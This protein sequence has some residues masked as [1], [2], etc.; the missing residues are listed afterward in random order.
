[1]ESLLKSQYNVLL[2]GQS[3]SGKTSTVAN[4]LASLDKRQI[5]QNI[6]INFSAR[7]TSLRVQQV[8]EDQLIQKG[9]TYLPQIGRQGIIYV[10]DLNM[11][12]KDQY[13][14]SQPIEF[15]RFFMDTKGFYDRKDLFWKNV[16]NTCILSSCAQP[17][18]GRETLTTRLTTSFVMFAQ[19]E[20]EDEGL[21]KIYNTILEGYLAYPDNKYPKDIIQSSAGVVKALIQIYHNLASILKPTPS[22]LHYS[23]N[24]RDVSKVIQG[25]MRGSSKILKTSEE[26]VRLFIHEVMRVF[27]DRT[28]NAFDNE[29][30]CK[31]VQEVLNTCPGTGMKK[32]LVYE[33]LFEDDGTPKQFDDTPPANAEFTEIW[34][35][36]MRFGT[37]LEERVYEAKELKQVQTTVYQYLD[38]YNTESGKQKMNLVLFNDAIMYV[39]K[40]ARILSSERGNLLN[41]GVGG[42]GRKSLTRLAAHI[43]EYSVESIQLKKGYSQSDFHEDVKGLYL[44]CG[45]KNENIVFLLDES[46]LVSGAILE[47]VNNILNSGLI[48]NLF[49]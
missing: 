45:L 47:D 13:E 29:Q 1:M 35:N 27:A 8:I 26:F 36:Y 31:C 10:D 34:G 9:K 6:Q 48:S 28:V 44:R 30:V 14:C 22:K 3:G 18:G 4:M 38:Q 2:T 33:Q 43:C 42:S 15:V 19:P 37:P 17:G 40:I 21:L 11:P 5:T 46:Q 41:V 20:A 49:D 7:T 32:Q 23:F 25:L 12:A 24:L 16:E 39:S